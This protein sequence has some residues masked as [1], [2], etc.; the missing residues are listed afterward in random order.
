MKVLQ[1]EG[2]SCNH[3]VMRVKKALESISEVKLAE[4]IL[5]EKQAK[6]DID[7]AVDEGIL[8]QAVEEAGYQVTGIA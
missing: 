3:C 5:D 6:V 4:V 1:I 7:G 2:M 8:K